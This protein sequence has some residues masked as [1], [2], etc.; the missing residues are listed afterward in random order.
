MAAVKNN[1]PVDLPALSLDKRNRRQIAVPIV[2]T[3]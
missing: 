1:G 2:V 3:T